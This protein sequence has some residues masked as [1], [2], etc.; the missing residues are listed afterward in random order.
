MLKR[1]LRALG[2]APA[3][4]SPAGS[5]FIAL[6]D[7]PLPAETRARDALATACAE[8]AVGNDRAAHR[9]LARLAAQSRAALAPALLGWLRETR[10]GGSGAERA[11]LSARACAD[12]QAVAE[13]LVDR[14]REHLNRN[15]PAAAE[16]CFLLAARLAPE[17]ALPL[18][19]LGFA[20]YLSGD[21]AAARRWYDLALDQADPGE[22][23]ALALN[24]LINTLPQIAASREALVEARAWFEGELRRLCADPP[25]LVDPLAQINRTTFFLAYQGLNDRDAS[26]ALA[27]LFLA[28]CPEL[29]FVAATARHAQPLGGRKPRIA[30]VSMNL[31]RQSVGVWY[32][33]YL[34]TLI[35]SGRLDISLFTYGGNVDAALKEAAVA[36]GRHEF[37]AP[38]L[39]EARAQI[40]AHKP[41]LLVYTDVG[42]HPFPYF[43]SMSRLAPR[44]AL[45]VG[46]PATSGVPGIDHFVSNVYQDG[47][48]AAAHYTEDLVRLPVIPVQVVR[49]AAPATLRTRA[50][51]GLVE[52]VRYYLCPMMLQK[53]HPDFDCA[54]QAILERDPD[55]EV[56]LFSDPARALW[57]QQLESRFTRSMGRVAQRVVFRPF[58]PKDEFLNLLLAAD[59]I[60][61]SFHFSGGVT[62]YIAL[63]LG[64]PLVTLPGPLFRSRM[65]AGML[66]QAGLADL[67]A[68]SVD[69]YVVRA[70]RLAC[71]P[72][73]R[74]TMRGRILAAHDRLFDT[75]SAVTPF[76]RWIEE[77]VAESA[78]R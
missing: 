26:A 63:S 1:F 69:D 44:Q 21:V 78:G 27:R 72:A 14:G 77:V 2:G 23:G 17:A 31:G 7:L 13:H 53:I 67:V 39:G 42:M 58:A 56:L 16:R 59:C 32:R 33:R 5:G 46:H 3:L 51:L 66:A 47:D 22:R 30:F 24:R 20:G 4:R 50:D 64:C 61:D 70:T 45:L 9:A 41:D 19:M 35:E 71:D 62:T 54:L 37:L 28:S 43:L 11:Y 55:G 34:R 10:M 15:A 57:Q 65:S 75:G 38:T 25:V 12:A 40:A 6:A 68:D 73:L 76:L 74:A 8:A 52:G 36:L 49:T 60:L 29:G 48:G 18:E